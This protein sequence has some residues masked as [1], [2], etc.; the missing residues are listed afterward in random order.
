MNILRIKK[1][2]CLLFG[3]SVFSG[4]LANHD[5]KIVIENPV[6]SSKLMQFFEYIFTVYPAQ[7]YHNLVTKAVVESSNDQEAYRYII[8]HLST[9]EQSRFTTLVTSLASLKQQ[10]NELADQAALF[11]GDKKI[12]GYLELGTPGRY[13]KALQ[14]R[15]SLSGE[16]IVA[17]YSSGIVN[18]IEREKIVSGYRTIPLDY[19]PLAI[20]EES[21]DLVSCFI[22]LHHIPHE[23]LDPFLDSVVRVL[24]PGGLFIVRD[25][26]GEPDFIPFL[27]VIHSVYN[28]GTGVSCED[29][30]AEVRLFKPISEWKHILARHGL[31]VRPLEL[32]QK[33]DP[34]ANTLLCFYKDENVQDAKRTAWEQELQKKPTY[35]REKEATYMT[36]PEWYTVDI[37]QQYGA[38]LEK[39]P[40]YSYPYMK[41]IGSYWAMWKNSL[42]TSYRKYG[43]SRSVFSSYTLMNT[44]V[45]LMMTG[46]FTGLSGLAVAPRYFYTNAEH[47]EPETVSAL[48]CDPQGAV[49]SLDSRIKIIN[50]LEGQFIVYVT[51]PRYKP[52]TEILKKLARS[53]CRLIQLGGHR[54]V[55]AKLFVRT[56][57]DIKYIPTTCEYLYENPSFIG[58]NELEAFVSIPLSA[59]SNVVQQL[60]QHGIEIVHFFDY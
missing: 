9:L 14:K 12:D 27:N 49:S 24:R 48:I 54:Q 43:L 55:Q 47:Q 59:L 38:F 18:I 57:D 33:G 26:D 31:K 6:L 19:S 50:T 41:A 53:N 15:C 30:Q 2:L 51:L 13:I 10:R 42:Q 28:A 17:P 29:E 25:H 8:D 3:L 21:L 4:T 16:T 32:L 44:T 34:S 7:K 46:V 1:K 60:D 11:L 52:C 20:S 37:V 35:L 39:T 22:G 56:K 5:Y 45:G 58:K 23:K 36:S 40:W